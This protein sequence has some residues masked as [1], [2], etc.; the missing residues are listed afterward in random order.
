MSAPRLDAL[1]RVHGPAARPGYDP[2]AHGVGILHLG[3]G[4]FHR[5][6]QAVATDD[7]LARS[8]GDWRNC[9]AWANR[10]RFVPRRSRWPNPAPT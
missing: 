9:S 5:A 3:I 8:G 10:R 1:D 7:A 6:H 4:A 2:A